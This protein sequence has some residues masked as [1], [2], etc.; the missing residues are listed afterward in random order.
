MRILVTRPPPGGPR[1]AARLRALGHEAIELPVIAVGP[2][3]APWPSGPFDA[4]VLTSANGLL[5]RPDPIPAALI[6]TPL[7]AVGRATA[8]A[9]TVAGFADVAPATGDAAGLAASLSAQVRGG[10]HF[11]YLAGAVRK[12]DLEQ[13]MA[14]AGFVVTVA[15]TYDARPVA[16]DRIAALLGD[17]PPDA[18]LH[19]SRASAQAWLAGVRA[20]GHEA[21]LLCGRHLALSPDVAEPLLRAGATDVRVASRPEED[22]LIGLLEE[23][24]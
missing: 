17:R 15:E 6:L 16:A 21:A 11:L 23:R 1:T 5:G 10:S 14:A 19:Y 22:A 4:V 2:T 7:F 18:V 9:A 24:G 8:A 13:A 20:G 3:G 12:P